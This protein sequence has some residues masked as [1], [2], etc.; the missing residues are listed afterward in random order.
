MA[1]GAKDEL[2]W[3]VCAAYDV[4]ADEVFVPTL[5]VGCIVDGSRENAI[6]E[7]GSE[8]LDL[9]FHLGDGGAGPAIRNVAVGPGGVVSGGGAGG[10]E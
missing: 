2:L 1:R 5:H 4:A 9:I 3:R 6:A 10:V 7:A 8:T